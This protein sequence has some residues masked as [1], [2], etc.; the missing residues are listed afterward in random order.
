MKRGGWTK[1]ITAGGVASLLLT[2]QQTAS[3]TVP[4]PRADTARQQTRDAA[5]DTAATAVEDVAESLSRSGYGDVTVDPDSGRVRVY[6][7]GT[8]PPRVRHRLAA[9]SPGTRIDVSPAKFTKTQLLAAQDVLAPALTDDP[10]GAEVRARFRIPDSIV[11]LDVAPGSGGLVAGIAGTGAA[12]RRIAVNGLS[13]PLRIR[14]VGSAP[15]DLTLPSRAG[16]S[17]RTPGFGGGA[18]LGKG[19]CTTG[20]TVWMSGNRT[21]ML[22]AAH[23]ADRGQI[24]R[25]YPSGGK[26]FPNATARVVA[27]DDSV[28]LELIKVDGY[29]E[30][31]D[32]FIAR[33]WVGGNAD[34]SKAESKPVQSVTRVHVGSRI[35]TSG[36]LSGE[37]CGLRVDST[38]A[39]QK[40]RKGRFVR[41]HNDTGGSAGGRGDSGG[42]AYTKGVI[43]VNAVGILSSGVIRA[44]CQGRTGRACYETLFISPVDNARALPGYRS[45]REYH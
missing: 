37:I 13:V 27:R 28:D 41:A 36:A 6:W 29:R 14:E 25:S 42:P 12:T 44:R 20:F 35:C 22:T 38:N 11:T 40:N 17:L 19:I 31:P 21:R 3:S 33:I 5:T 2:A 16:S 26:F 30:V 8:M 18:F 1:L 15:Q 32:S 7:K 45:V 10:A 23:C 34:S 9:A 43:G 4:G 24:V 39:M